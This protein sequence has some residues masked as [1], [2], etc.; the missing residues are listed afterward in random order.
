MDG[1]NQI[2]P[3]ATGVAQDAPDDELTEW[4]TAKVKRRM[5]KSAN[6]TVKGVHERKVYEIR[7]HKKIHVVYLEKGLR[8]VAQ[9]AKPWFLNRNLKGTYSGIIYPVRDVSSW[10]TPDDFPLVLPPILGK[11]LPGRPK[12]KDRIPSQGEGRKNNNCGRCGS[13]GHNRTA[14][15]VPVPKKQ[16]TGSKR[17]K[18][19]HDPSGNIDSQPHQDHQQPNQGYNVQMMYEP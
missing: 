5:L 14:C 19:T 9:L 8:S 4:A 16:T 10:H 18:S 12:K 15:N 11:N 2:I 13:K 17:I 3:I 6:W 7:E 1:N